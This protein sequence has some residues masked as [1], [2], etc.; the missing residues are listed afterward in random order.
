MIKYLVAIF[1]FLTACDAGVT[2][3][4]AKDTVAHH[5]KDTITTKIVNDSIINVKFSK[6]SQTATVEGYIKDYNHPVMITVPVAKADTLFATLSTTDAAANIRFNQV[7]MPDGSAD[8][9]FGR[10]LHYPVKQQG[11]YTIKVG[12]DLMAEGPYQGS[13]TVTISLR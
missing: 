4:D 3:N 13:F 5:L 2:K 7:F 8:G 1:L 10:T 6:G 9:P 11:V 12:E